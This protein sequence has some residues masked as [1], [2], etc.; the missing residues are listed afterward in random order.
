MTF[1]LYFRTLK[2]FETYLKKGGRSTDYFIPPEVCVMMNT[3]IDCK[4][5]VNRKEQFLDFSTNVLTWGL[6]IL[7]MILPNHMSSHE[8]NHF[9]ALLM[10]LFC[11][12]SSVILGMKNE[13]YTCDSIMIIQVVLMFIS[14]ILIYH[15]CLYVE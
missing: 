15:C 9:V 1:S 6:C 12:R 5:K 7:L 2:S 14:H 4:N 13:R 11:T 10:F 3:I 8:F